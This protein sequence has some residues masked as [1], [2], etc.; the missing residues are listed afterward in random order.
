MRDSSII[1]DESEGNVEVCAQLD[2]PTGGI[3]RDVTVQ[4]TS[5]EN[6]STG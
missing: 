5:T 1:R 2:G 6:G 4:L 3:E